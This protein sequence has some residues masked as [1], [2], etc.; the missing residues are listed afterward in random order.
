[1]NQTETL[2]IIST[3]HIAQG[4]LA[5]AMFKGASSISMKKEPWCYKVNDQWEIKCNGQSTEVDNI[6]PYS[7]FITFNGWPAGVLSIM[8]EGVLCA[9]VA[10]NE[11][12][13]R[14]ALINNIEATKN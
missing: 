12:A 2:E 4:L 14:S 9:G 7:W 5:F 11:E 8:G 10:G 3:G 6:P 1:M 13:L